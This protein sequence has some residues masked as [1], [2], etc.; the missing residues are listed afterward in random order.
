MILARIFGAA[1]A[2]PAPADFGVELDSAML[3]A[4]LASC[5]APTPASASTIR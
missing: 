4:H 3:P 5:R 2:L 1:E